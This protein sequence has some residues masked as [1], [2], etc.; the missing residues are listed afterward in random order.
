MS[1]QYNSQSTKSLSEKARGGARWGIGAL[2]FSGTLINYFDRVNLSV[3]A[4]PLGREFHVSPGQI[5]ILL[6]A[7]SW[8]YLLLQIP[9]GTLL[10][11]I[12]VKWLGRIS[13][14]LWSLATFLTALVGGFG[15]LMVAQV[16][17]G[18]SEA[19][20]FP[21]SSKATSYWFPYSERGLATSSF[22]AAAKF[23]NVIGVPLVALAVTLWGWQGGFWGTG[24]LSTLYAIGFWIW[25]RNPREAKV[26][27]RLS[28]AEYT[29]IIEGGAQ[30]ET[31]LPKNQL[32]SLRHLLRQR[33][34]WGLSLGFGA[35]NYAFYVFLNWLPGYLQSQLHM[36]ILK[37][38][39]YTAIP[40]LVAT[41]ADIFLG[42]WLVDTLIRRGRDQSKVRMVMLVVGMLLGLAVIGAAFTHNPNI[43]IFWISL[44]LGGLAFSAPVGW[45]ITAIIA[46][47]G[48][49]GTL[50]GIF[51]CISGL[52]ALPAPIITGYIVQDTGSFATAFI[53]AGI[54]LAF[55]IFCYVFL[56]GR[57]E[58][59]P[60]LPAEQEHLAENVAK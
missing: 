24:A 58:Q 4:Q 53:T 36:T 51:N 18:V 23:S 10:D 31:V 48:T 20:A 47:E 56:L 3:V 44:S 28:D 46:P 14:I 9:V 12:G 45:S 11:K 55:G 49:V 25:Y 8:S 43:A 15:G 30:D 13:A 29:Y 26:L 5:G 32:A 2:L 59:I 22:D 52:M 38:G 40:W 41:A 39:W 16:L 54:V 37:S 34:V 42:G 27:H 17:L 50:G 35:Y 6:S 57:I 33:K 1:L 7:F 19:P 60:T 21:A